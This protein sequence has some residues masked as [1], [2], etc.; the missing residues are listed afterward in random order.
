MRDQELTQLQERIRDLAF[1]EMASQAEE[2]IQLRAMLEHEKVQNRAWASTVEIMEEDVGEL[3][4]EKEELEDALL[5]A[6]AA[7][8]VYEQESE[9]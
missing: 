1:E 3:R 4:A 2:L 5:A 7:I 9:L 8:A 6:Q